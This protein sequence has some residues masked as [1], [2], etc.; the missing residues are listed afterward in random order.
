MK[1]TNLFTLGGLF[2]ILLFSCQKEKL[3]NTIEENVTNQTQANKDDLD[4]EID[5]NDIRVLFIGNSFTDN[6]TVKIPTMVKNLFDYNN[7]S[8][9]VVASQAS[10]GWTLQDHRN[11]LVTQTAINQGDWDYVILQENSGM[12]YYDGAA[13]INQ[14]RNSV[15]D[16]VDLINNQ[17]P[18]AKI[19]LYQVVPPVEENTSSY[20]NTQA[21]WNVLFADVADDNDIYVINIGQAFTNAYNG[22]FGFDPAPDQL[23]YGSGS[24]HHYQNS[25]GFLSSVTFYTAIT[26]E[27]PLIPS[28]MN[29]YLGSGN[30][31]SGNVSTYVPQATALGWVGY[32]EGWNSIHSGDVRCFQLPEDGGGTDG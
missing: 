26:N 9:D 2:L 14:F 15:E 4:C 18:N 24:Q 7:I 1:K 16:L 19:A 21:S 28:T 8:Y 32:S 10:L 22:Q 12:L 13:G 11:S 25:G 20:N 27:K 17:S 29:F 30:N 6:Y 31:G 3:K 23:R 5:Q